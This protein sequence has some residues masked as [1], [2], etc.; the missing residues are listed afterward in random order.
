MTTIIDGGHGIQLHVEEG[1][2]RRRCGDCQ[3]CCKLVPV[4]NLGKPAGQR[5]KYQRVGKGCTV[6]ARLATISNACLMW[7]CRWL[8]QNDTA[9]LRRPDRSHYVLDVMPDYI[10]IRNNETGTAEYVEVVQIWVDP[11]Y[12]EAHR[13]PALRAYIERRSHEGVAVLIRWDNT[14]GMVIF[15]PAMSGDRE[16]HEVTQALSSEQHSM[17]DVAK[18]LG[19]A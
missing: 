16:W 7:N 5:C 12:P 2:L 10:T 1:E 11:N 13:D 15:A 8:V 6:H 3:L 17:A 14:K 9:D 19:A 18:A 4:A